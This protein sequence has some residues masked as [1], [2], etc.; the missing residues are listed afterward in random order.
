MLRAEAQS[1]SLRGA[2]RRS[3]PDWHRGGSLDCFASLAMTML[4][5]V[6]RPRISL[7]SCGLREL[8]L[9][10]LR[11]VRREE[12]TRRTVDDGGDLLCRR[13]GLGL[14]DERL[15]QRRLAHLHEL[16]GGDL[17]IVD[18]ELAELAARLEISRE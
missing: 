16:P 9:L 5:H 10:R 6:G 2:K 11:P 14:E 12:H 17:I 15:E 3:N 4:N 8:P 18:R 7:R 1:S 13:R